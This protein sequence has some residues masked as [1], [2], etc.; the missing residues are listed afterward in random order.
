[1]SD[2]V[3]LLWSR[4]DY[5]HDVLSRKGD[6]TAG[7]SWRAKVRHCAALGANI[8]NTSVFLYGQSFRILLILNV[9]GKVK[10]HRT[11]HRRRAETT[12]FTQSNCGADRKAYMPLLFPLV[13]EDQISI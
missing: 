5:E 1:M 10:V 4:D 2:G 8:S 7:A 12:K 6:R 11:R 9:E 13:A 3:H